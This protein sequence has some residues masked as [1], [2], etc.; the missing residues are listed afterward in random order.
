LS[1]EA[2]CITLAAE[3]VNSLDSIKDKI[4]LL[5]IQKLLDFGLAA[6][7]QSKTRET[8]QFP[9]FAHTGHWYVVGMDEKSERLVLLC[10]YLQ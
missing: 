10:E 7:Q 8:T 1:C 4:G 5:L 3:P 6:P 2:L 9:V